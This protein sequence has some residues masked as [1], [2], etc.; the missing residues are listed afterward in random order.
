MARNPT[1]PRLPQRPQFRFRR[2]GMVC[3]PDLLYGGPGGA[4]GTAVGTC[5]SGPARAGPRGGG[6]GGERRRGGRGGRPQSPPELPPLE[7][8]QPGT[9]TEGLFRRERPRRGGRNGETAGRGGSGLALKSEGG[10]GR[11]LRGRGRAAHPARAPAR[12]PRP[13]SPPPRPAPGGGA[14]PPPGKPTPPAPPPPPPSLSLLPSGNAHC[15]W[16]R[17]YSGRIIQRPE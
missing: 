15:Q 9:C 12:A 11:L 16:A 10:E 3:C 1:A 2:G 13:P 6:G 7:D 4:R 5:I 14:E 8:C 17:G